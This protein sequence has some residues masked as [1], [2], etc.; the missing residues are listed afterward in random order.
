MFC[1]SSSKEQPQLIDWVIH[2]QLFAHAKG[3]LSS[4]GLASVIAVTDCCVLI[5]TLLQL[6]YSLNSLYALCY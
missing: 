4:S 5:M 3:L 1:F 6:Y 2:H